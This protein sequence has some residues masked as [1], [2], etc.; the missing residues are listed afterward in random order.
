MTRLTACGVCDS[1]LVYPRD[2]YA[3]QTDFAVVERRCPECETCDH[4]VCDPTAAQAWLRRQLRDRRQLERLVLAIELD[5]I[6]AD[7]APTSR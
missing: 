6:L 1:P 3:I 4:V 5:D 2:V 7:A